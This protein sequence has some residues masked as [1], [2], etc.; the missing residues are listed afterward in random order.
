MTDHYQKFKRLFE[1]Y[2]YKL[3]RKFPYYNTE[4]NK[5]KV[6]NFLKQLSQKVDLSSIGNN[7]LIDYFSW[8]FSARSQQKT[9]REISFNWIVGKKML[10]QWFQ[11][12]EEHSWQ[13]QQFLKE[14]SINIEQLKSDL[15]ESE[16]LSSKLDPLEEKEKGRLGGEP[17]LYN[18]LQ[19]T[20]LYN[21]RSIIC[22]TCSNKIL[23]KKL[24]AEKYP[25]IYEKRGYAVK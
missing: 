10:D 6:D 23:C 2:Y 18:C 15:V 5:I 9:K 25:K 24:L 22:L 12:T 17:Q 19:F 4:Q 16:K 14:Y 3:Y 8:S 7:W 20:T 1:F 13:Y 11:K 21:S